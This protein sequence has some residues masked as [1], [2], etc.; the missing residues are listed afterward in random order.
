M[1]DNL[2]TMCPEI[3]EKQLHLQKNFSEQWIEEKKN[4]KRNLELAVSLGSVPNVKVPENHCLTKHNYH[5][6]KKYP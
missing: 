4:K 3:T 6:S 1:S 5:Y 2:I